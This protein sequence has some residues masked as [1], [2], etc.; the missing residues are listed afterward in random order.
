MELATLIYIISMLPAINGWFMTF[1][2]GFTALTVVGTAFYWI[3][4]G[5]NSIDIDVIL[6]KKEDTLSTADK[7][8]L[9]YA[10]K[11]L[12]WVKGFLAAAVVSIAL[13]VVTPTEKT[14]WIMVGAY[15]TQEIATTVYNNERARELGDKTLKIIE[16]KMDSVLTELVDAGKDTAKKAAK[17]VEQ[18]V[19]EKAG[20]LAK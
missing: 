4:K 9:R 19:E 3:W 15:A 2:I 12:K 1:A 17:V 13:S 11:H 8:N 5:D 6:S 20:E 18:K 7:A 16:A 10:A 14:A